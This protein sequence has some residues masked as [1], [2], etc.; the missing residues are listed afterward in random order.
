MTTIL[1]E[2]GA[3]VENVFYED[4]DAEVVDYTKRIILDSLA[5]LYGGINSKPAS[6]VHEAVEE[7]G[8]NHQSTIIS[9]GAKTSMENAAIANGVA[10]RYLDYNDIYFGPAWT[11]HASDNLATLLA[12]AEAYGATGKDLILATVLAYE[13]Q[14]SFSDLPVERN[15]WHGGWHHSAACSY[16]G[17]AGVGKLLKLSGLQIAHGMAL[18]GARANTFAQIRHGDIPMDKALSAPLVASRS[19]LSVLLA[20]LGFTGQTTI[21]EG[22]YGFK[23]AVAAGADVGPLVPTPNEPF[24]IMKNGLKP[25]PVEG[26]TPAMVEAALNLREQVADKI[27]EISEITIYVHK[28]ATTKPSWDQSKM[29]PDS[30]E[31]ADHSF[32]FCVAIALVAGQVTPDEFSNEWLF[33][34]RIRRLIQCTRFEVEDRLTREFE[35]G[36]R[37]ARVE[38]RIGGDTFSEEILRPLGSPERKMSDEQIERKFR[39]MAA[40]H[41]PEEQMVGVVRRILSLEAETDVASLVEALVVPGRT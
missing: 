30:K 37:P 15:L 38:I 19:I 40:S 20:R 9:S 23:Y 10:L 32:P 12:V 26:M 39:T 6:M 27:D 7:L 33:D 14:M 35:A 8:G 24:R 1:E 3:Y 28:E 36:G 11:S 21:L 16:S 25:W 29:M 22:D 5:C 13:I 41:L 2:M 34:E 31:T 17:A 4:L 18:S